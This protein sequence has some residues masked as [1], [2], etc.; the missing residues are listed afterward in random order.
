MPANTYFLSV[1]SDAGNFGF[2][3]QAI[4]IGGQVIGS[5]GTLTLLNTFSGGCP[6]RDFGTGTTVL[7]FTSPLFLG[8]GGFAAQ[9]SETYLIVR[10]TGA[11]ASGQDL[12]SDDDGVFNTS[13]GI[14]VLDGFALLVNPEEEFIY[15]A[16]A[17]VVNISDAADTDQPDA[18]TRFPGNLTPFVTTA[19]YFGELAAS[20]DNTTAYVAPLSANFPAGGQLTPG[21]QNAP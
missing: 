19:F 14:T 21:A 9:G 20:P 1:N 2:A 4:N 7:S 16:D 15:G 12:D 8:G 5:N 11:L 17:G 13:L 18:V 3:N 10:S 6:G